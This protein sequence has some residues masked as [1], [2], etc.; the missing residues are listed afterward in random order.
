MHRNQFLERGIDRGVFAADAG[1]GQKAEQREDREILCERAG[2][3]GGDVDPERDEE[4]PLAAEAIGEP[5]EEERAEHRAGEIRA[6][7]R[8][9][10]GVGKLQHR[11]RF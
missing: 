2:G 3:S 10:L 6:C 7:R 9:D 11:T 5:A 8:A 1:A 4:Q